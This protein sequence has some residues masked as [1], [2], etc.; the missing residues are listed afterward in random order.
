MKNIITPL[1]L[2]ALFSSVSADARATESFT[3]YQE[4]RSTS[5]ENLSI[6]G[7]ADFRNVK[8]ANGSVTG[9]VEFEDLIK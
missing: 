9:D 5:F 8:L 6:N 2:L 1:L 4:F 7:S 3:G